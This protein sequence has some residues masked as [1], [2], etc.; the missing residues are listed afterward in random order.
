MSIVNIV[1]T[2][3]HSIPA[4][5][6]RLIDKLKLPADARDIGIKINLCNYKRAE[7]GVTTDPQVLDPLLKILR[8]KYPSSEIYLF[9][10]DA[11]GTLADN[12]FPWLGLD[13]IIGR[14]D[15]KFVNIAH[16]KWEK[17]FVHG[18]R[19]NEVEVPSKL[20]S[21][22]I[23]NHPKLKTHGRTKIS[24]GLKNIFGCYRIKEKVKY[25]HFLDKA[26]ADI[27]MAIKSDFVIVDGYLALEGNRGPTQGYP[28]KVG[29]FVGGDDVVAVDSCCARFMGF[30][31][32]SVGHIVKAR[33][34]GLGSM[35]Y[36]LNSEIAKTDFRTYQFEYSI[37]KYWLMQAARRFLQ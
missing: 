16:E 11:T 17:V 7:T 26:I 31:P 23:V 18:Y 33:R 32:R 37:T 12:L 34:K 25:H 2:N 35:K 8:G 10:N 36:K 14:Y 4:S 3:K 27:N 21:S 20:L 28:K 29:I 1:K 24:C 19:F 30:N 9:E 6:S 22:L 5:L 15:V 13:K